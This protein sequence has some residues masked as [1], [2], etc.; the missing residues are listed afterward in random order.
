[1]EA[2]GAKFSINQGNE[3]KNFPF[4]NE[5]ILWDKSKEL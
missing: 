1:M 2:N 3:K 4:D 5:K